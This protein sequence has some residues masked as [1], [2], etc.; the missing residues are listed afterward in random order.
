MLEREVV[1]SCQT[2]LDIGCGEGSHV[3]GIASQIEYSVGIDSFGPSLE[4]AKQ[5]GVYTETKLMSASDVRNVFDNDSFDCV[6]AFDLIEH[7]EKADGWRLLRNME[8]LATK[9]VIVF[10]PNGFLPQGP[11]HDN[12][13]QVH[14]SGWSVSEMR[15][16][17]Y[18]VFGIHGIKPLLCETS[19]PRWKPKKFWKALSVL[20]Q[21][22]C[23]GLPKIAFQ[24]FC[25]KE[26]C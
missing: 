15:M 18:R 4:I 26:I 14:R 6:V 8:S 24:I 17:G 21:P 25:V 23:L 10:T 9:K 19:S 13:Y 7:L 5:R 11:L 16:C 1:G 20:T 3:C 22:L 2:L 12:K